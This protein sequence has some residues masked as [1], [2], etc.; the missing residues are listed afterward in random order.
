MSLA[1][2]GDIRGH[3]AFRFAHAGYKG[4]HMNFALIAL[5]MSGSW[6]ICLFSSISSL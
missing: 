3:P 4:P 6:R 2:R 5:F 1:Q